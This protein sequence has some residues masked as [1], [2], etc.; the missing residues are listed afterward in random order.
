ME[1]GDFINP[2]TM[3]VSQ[4][5]P[6][7]IPTKTPKISPTPT[8][9]PPQPDQSSGG[10]SSSSTDSCLV[11]CSDCPEGYCHDCNQNQICDERESP[12]SG[13]E[14]GSHSGIDTGGQSENPQ[15]PVLPSPTVTSQSG[16]GQS[17]NP[18]V[19]PQPTQT[20]EQEGGISESAQGMILAMKAAGN[21]WTNE[22]TDAVTNNPKSPTLITFKSDVHIISLSTY[23]WNN[24]QGTPFVGTIGLKDSAGK[25][26]GPW[27]ATGEK[28]QGGVPNARW[29]AVPDTDS[30]NRFTFKQGT[31]SILDSDP[32]TWSANAKSN[33]Q[34]FCTI[35]YSI[36]IKTDSLTDYSNG[37]IAKLDINGIQKRGG[38]S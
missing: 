29:T 20:P 11:S 7:P 30:S 38:I 31:Y 23:H 4:P 18:Q 28:G 32:E 19:I 10:G 22:N 35:E 34:G 8:I 15:N 27:Q 14:T 1:T 36:A 37:S 13:S 16:G 2:N 3:D 12:A 17:E 21:T 9:I 5:N 33:D 25:I 26:F 24:G 6:S